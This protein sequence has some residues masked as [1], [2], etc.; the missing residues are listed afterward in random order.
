VPDEFEGQ[1]RRAQKVLRVLI[2]SHISL[3]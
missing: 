3:L 1:S 2:Y